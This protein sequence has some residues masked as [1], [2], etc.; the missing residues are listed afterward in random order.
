MQFV[1]T[2]PENKLNIHAAADGGGAEQT[3]LTI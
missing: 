2:A 1:A 3:K